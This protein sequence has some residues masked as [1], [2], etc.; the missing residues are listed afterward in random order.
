MQNVAKCDFKCKYLKNTIT[1]GLLMRYANV[2]LHPLSVSKTWNLNRKW[3]LWFLSL[4]FLTYFVQF[5][6]R[7]VQFLG[8]YLELRTLGQDIY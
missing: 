6:A 3:K 5:L 2:S 4:T 8:D 7:L 1:L